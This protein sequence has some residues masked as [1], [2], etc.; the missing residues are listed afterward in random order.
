MSTPID[1]DPGPST[2]N[3]QE[4]VSAIPGLALDE[5]TKIWIK[6]WGPSIP[7]P[8][9]LCGTLGQGDLESVSQYAPALFPSVSNNLVAREVL[10][11]LSCRNIS[12][13]TD[14][15]LAR[16]ASTHKSYTTYI[17]RF[18]VRTAVPS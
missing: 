8:Q 17:K 13:M 12:C 5:A 10:K 16:A 3:L 1:P 6:K 2:C 7:V 11:V 18:T 15:Y 9:T 14:L 4:F